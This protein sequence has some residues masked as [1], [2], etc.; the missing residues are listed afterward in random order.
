MK[1]TDLK[2]DTEEYEYFRKEVSGEA[3]ALRVRELA[4]MYKKQKVL[5]YGNGIYFDAIC[6]CYD[7]MECFDIVGVSDL[8]YESSGEIEYKGFKT[9]KPSEIGT[10]EVD[11]ILVATLS[12]EAIKKSLLKIKKVDVEHLRPDFEEQKKEVFKNYENLLEQLKTKDK[13][14]VAFL[15][16]ENAK[17]GYQS[18]YESLNENERFDVLPIV[19]LSSDGNVSDFFKSRGMPVCR[20]N[21][22]NLKP[23]VVFYEQT[24]GLPPPLHPICVSEYALTLIV[25]YGFFLIC[26]EGWRDMFAQHKMDCFWKVLAESSFH[27]DFYKKAG[28]LENTVVT[29]YPKLDSYLEPSKSSPWKGDG[30]RII[31]APHWSLDGSTLQMSNFIEHYGFF[32]DFAGEHKE[33]SFILKPHP[34]LRQACEDSKLLDYDE[35][36]EQ[37]N[38]LENAVV[39]DKGDYFGI[40]KTSDVMITDSSSFLAEYYPSKKPL[41]FMNKSSRSGFNDFGKRLVETFYQPDSLAEIDGLLKTLLLDGKDILKPLREKTLKELFGTQR[42]QPDSEPNVES[43]GK[44]IVSMLLDF[45]KK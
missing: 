37:W 15:S 8:R 44:G 24:W 28:G 18:V 29:G 36:I 41:I 6:D 22:K 26:E 16:S 30:R 25:S 12:F 3:F 45:L 5:I 35:Y 34:R 23:D 14:R 19:D 17:W 21:L 9:F 2:K 43:V 42:S 33:Y 32:L 38:R 10:L 39:Y 4:S 7:L 11:V 27:K 20:D 1:M 40:F 31:W 13:I